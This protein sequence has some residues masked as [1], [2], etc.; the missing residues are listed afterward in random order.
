M[1]QFWGKDLTRSAP[2]NGPLFK[3]MSEKII[4]GNEGAGELSRLLR[5]YR[6][7]PDPIRG[8]QRCAL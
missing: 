2:S 4:P 7:R 1:L 5:Q 3:L 8:D 6:M